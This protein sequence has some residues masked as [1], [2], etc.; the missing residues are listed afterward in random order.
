VIPS[1]LLD[2]SV[3]SQ[4]IKNQPISAAL[5]RWSRLGEGAVCTSA[6][7]VAE[8]RQGLEFR[9]SDKY[10][11]RYQ[12]L[13]EDRYAVLPFDHAVATTFGRL[14]AVVRRRGRPV[15]VVDLM[16]AATAKHHG[17]IVATLN[18]KHF[19]GIPGLAVE[20]WNSE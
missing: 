11:D 12:E 19:A 8:V 20:D 6:I 13:L 14:A 17:L 15:P 1:H 16:I 5:T 10:W 18:V 4:P 3:F 7:C 2:T 9:A